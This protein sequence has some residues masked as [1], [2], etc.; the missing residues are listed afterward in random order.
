[1]DKSYPWLS[2]AN[3]TLDFTFRIGKT[4]V[5]YVYDDYE[6]PKKHHRIKPNSLENTQL[7]LA[8]DLDDE[9][10]VAS[11]RLYVNQE[12]GHNDDQ[13]KATL[14]GYNI[15]QT[16]V[17]I[18]SHEDTV[19]IPMYAERVETV[20]IPEPMLTRKTSSNDISNEAK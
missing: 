1:M 7:A 15:N 6:V 10:I 12:Q 5:Q 20:D 9:L 18:W 4:L 3:K 17:C 14:V 8:F 2:L 16:P 11:W 13:L 19:N